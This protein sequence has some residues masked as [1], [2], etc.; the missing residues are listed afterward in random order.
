MKKRVSA[1]VIICIMLLSAMSFPFVTVLAEERVDCEDAILEDTGHEDIALE[2]AI[3]DGASLGGGIGGPGGGTQEEFILRLDFDIPFCVVEKQRSFTLEVGGDPRELPL[4][5]HIHGF[6]SFMLWTRCEIE[7]RY[8]D[9]SSDEPGKKIIVG[10]VIIHPEDILRHGT[11]FAP[12]CNPFVELEVTVYESGENGSGDDICGCACNCAC[13]DGDCDCNG[14][15]IDTGCCE[16]DKDLREGLF[17]LDEPIAVMGNL[18]S[19]WSKAVESPEL[20]VSIDGGNTWKRVYDNCCDEDHW[21]CNQAGQCVSGD[22]GREIV[23]Y[24]H[25]NPVHSYN[26]L[27]L[28]INMVGLEGG[29]IYEFEVQ[30]SD[31][32]I[33]ID[34]IRLDTSSSGGWQNWDGRGLGG[35]RNRGDRGENTL[36]PPHNNPPPPPNNDL[37]PPPNNNPPPPSNDDPPPSPNDDPPSPNNNEDGNG[38]RDNENVNNGASSQQQRQ[39][40]DEIEIETLAYIDYTVAEEEVPAVLLDL[41]SATPRDADGNEEILQHAIDTPLTNMGDSDTSISAE[42]YLP[43]IISFV[44]GLAVAGTYITLKLRKRVTPR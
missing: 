29:H 27:D 5:D 20:W 32:V 18:L 8:D 12:E 40:S 7:W 42:N 26:I 35:D 36:P 10:D 39:F 23:I 1:T 37:P 2:D 21:V 6:I 22:T 28:S 17:L 44:S 24:H 38:S 34:G 14:D 25:F 11:R 16:D 13:D 3:L 31:G 9:F 15:C 43:V 41:P 30:Y 19:R 33:S 4:P